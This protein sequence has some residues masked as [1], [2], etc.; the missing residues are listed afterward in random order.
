[1]SAAVSQRFPPFTRAGI[2]KNFNWK[3]LLGQHSLFESLDPKEV[4]RIIVQLLDDKVSD[5]REYAEG[6]IIVREGEPGASVFL[7]GRGSVQV[8]LE[9]DNGAGTPI[10][11]LRQG[12]FFGEMSLLEKKPR[13]ATVKA[14]ENCI[15]LEIKGQEFLKLLDEHKDVESKML[16]KLSERLRHANDQVLAGRMRSVDDKLERFNEKFDLQLREARTLTDHTKGQADYIVKSFE[17]T[18]TWLTWILYFVITI[19]TLGGMVGG[20]VGYWYFKEIDRLFD[21]AKTSVKQIEEFDVKIK[22]TRNNIAENLVRPLFRDALK[23]ENITDAV[24]AYEQFQNFQPGEFFAPLYEIHQALVNI[25][26]PKDYTELLKKIVEEAKAADKAAEV[27]Q[28]Y[29]LLLTNLI[30]VKDDTLLRDTFKLN[31][32]AFEKYL[33]DHK[34]SIKDMP[35]IETNSFTGI[36]KVKLEK[37]RDLNSLTRKP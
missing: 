16:L 20:G 23:K 21:K 29:Y 17:N 19:L 36:N 22:A 30:L 6:N 3:D 33:R 4:E 5:E 9:G 25:K 8:V 15:L 26:P 7:V 1:L 11:T 35:I 18:R 13:A 10:S 28:A 37:L 12:E 2:V 27:M 32:S 14:R 34:D 31:F 24:V